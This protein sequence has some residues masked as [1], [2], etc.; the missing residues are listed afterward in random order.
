MRT[1]LALALLFNAVSAK[2]SEKA[3]A[4]E[5]K[6]ADPCKSKFRTGSTAPDPARAKMQALCEAIPQISHQ[7]HPKYKKANMNI[8]PEAEQWIEAQEDGRSA[9]YDSKYQHRVLG[10]LLARA[11]A[12]ALPSYR[13]H[14]P[15]IRL[16][17]LA[18]R[19]AAVGNV[20]QEWD[21]RGVGDPGGQPRSKT[22]R[23]RLSKQAEL[24]SRPGAAERCAANMSDPGGD[25]A[26]WCCGGLSVFARRS[27]VR[28]A[29][30]ADSH[31]PPCPSPLLSW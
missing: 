7:R 8:I 12:N 16:A 4:R 15:A 6:Y 20:I 27:N 1:W 26:A 23:A 18:M 31:A 21:R 9:S 25:A 24:I 19:R 28:Q 5:R 29:A 22:L 10:E 2:K 17:P 30:L 3:K 14:V 11:I 13:A